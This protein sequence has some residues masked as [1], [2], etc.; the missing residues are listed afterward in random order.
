MSANSSP[1]FGLTSLLC[2]N[3][4]PAPCDITT[5]VC[6]CSFCALRSLTMIRV[7]TAEEKILK[8][9]MQRLVVLTDSSTVCVW[10]GAQGEPGLPGASGEP[11]LAGLPGPM[12]PAG[13]PGPPGPPGPS[14]RNVGFV[15]ILLC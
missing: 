9:R 6:V 15:S 13:Q 8:K 11:G 12:G 14:Y 5:C 2:R 3:L 10:Q 1:Q 4:I 7:T